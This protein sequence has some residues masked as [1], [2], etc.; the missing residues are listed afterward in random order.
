MALGALFDICAE[1]VA[2]AALTVGPYRNASIYRD[3]VEEWSLRAFGIG[4]FY[5]VVLLVPPSA[6]VA[7]I[8]RQRVQQLNREVKD[9]NLSKALVPRVDTHVFVEP[10]GAEYAEVGDITP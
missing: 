2:S 3:R 5:D 1:I 4:W 8:Y 10:F 6:D 9:R 7:E